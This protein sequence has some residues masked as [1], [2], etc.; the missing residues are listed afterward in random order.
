MEKKINTSADKVK[1]FR[2]EDLNKSGFNKTVAPTPE[3]KAI[4]KGVKQ[5]SKQL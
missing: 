4:S 2:G 3:R 1:Y 5:M